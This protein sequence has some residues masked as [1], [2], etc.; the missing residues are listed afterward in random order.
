MVMEGVEGVE[1]VGGCVECWRVLEG[2]KCVG[3]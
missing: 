3:G 1:G 2:V